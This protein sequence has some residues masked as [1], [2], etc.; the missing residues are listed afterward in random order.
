MKS[1]LV[2]KWPSKNHPSEALSGG[3]LVRQSLPNAATGHGI[4]RSCGRGVGPCDAELGDD[5]N[6]STTAVARHGAIAQRCP[7]RHWAR[8]WVRVSDLLESR[9][10]VE[11]R[12]ARIHAHCVPT[13]GS[14]LEGHIV[15]ELLQAHR[16]RTLARDCPK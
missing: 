5:D 14:I 8:I 7:C 4:S 6:T 10:R 13:S 9:F 11:L 12:F 16:P 3:A 2:G 15:R 1:F